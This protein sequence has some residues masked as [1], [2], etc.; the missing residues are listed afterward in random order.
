[1]ALTMFRDEMN[2]KALVLFC[3]LIAFKTIY[4]VLKDRVDYVS[5]SCAFQHTT[6]THTH[7]HTFTHIHTHSHTFTH[8][9]THTSSTHVSC[10]G[11]YAPSTDITIPLCCGV[12]CG[13]C[14]PPFSFPFLSLFFPFSFPFLSPLCCVALPPQMLQ[15]VRLTWRFHLAIVCATAFVLLASC[16][17]VLFAAHTVYTSGVSVQLLFG[18]EYLVLIV[19]ASSNF[20]KYLVYAVD[21]QRENPWEQRAVYLALLDIVSDLTRLV[22]YMA[23]F[24]I[25]VNFYTVP[26]HLLRDLFITFSCVS[27]WFA[28]KEEQV[29][30][31]RVLYSSTPSLLHSLASPLLHSFTPSLLHSFTPARKP[32]TCRSFVRRVR[33]FQRARRVLAR[34]NAALVDATQEEL[35][36]SP[37]C[38]ICLEDM[39]AGKK[40]VAPPPFCCALLCAFALWVWARKRE[41]AWP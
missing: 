18:F 6:H 35:R 17:Y 40:F 36:D 10:F 3:I 38:N 28:C 34:L 29:L 32:H 7:S 1:M 19:N 23:F 13:V 11:G 21:L 33:D 22:A 5:P 25:L 16:S 31:V 15:T 24:G 14:N 37:A 8:T 20:V 4:W 12:L 9:F 41:K 30:L 39:D 27:L 26:L 2:S